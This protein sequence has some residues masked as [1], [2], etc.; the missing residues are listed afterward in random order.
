MNELVGSFSYVLV[1]FT[2]Q[3]TGHL[4]ALALALYSEQFW[5]VSAALVAKAMGATAARSCSAG[6]GN[7]SFTTVSALR[8]GAVGVSAAVPHIKG[9]RGEIEATASVPMISS[10]QENPE[11]Q[12]DTLI[13]TL[14]Q[15]SQGEEEVRTFRSALLGLIRGGTSSNITETVAAASVPATNMGK[16]SGKPSLEA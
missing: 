13:A 1:C 3:G 5:P 9:A 8:T 6:R 15:S 4:Q 10:V 2:A 16:H 11:Q 12:I 7:R 14:C